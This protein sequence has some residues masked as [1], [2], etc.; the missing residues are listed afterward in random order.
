[1]KNTY[2]NNDNK[3]ATLIIT[4][5]GCRVNFGNDFRNFPTELEAEEYLHEIGYR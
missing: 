3:K 1:M 2:V 5:S 4:Q